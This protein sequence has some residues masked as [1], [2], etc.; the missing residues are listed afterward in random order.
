M[1]TTDLLSGAAFIEAQALFPADTDNEATPF[2]ILLSSDLE[3]GVSDFPF[4]LN[5]T[6]DRRDPV[7]AEMRFPAEGYIDYSGS[8]RGINWVMALEKIASGWSIERGLVAFGDEAGELQIS[9]TKTAPPAGA[10]Y[11]VDAL[12]GATLTSVGV[13]NLVRFWMGENGFGPFLKNL[14]AG[15][16]S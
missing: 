7:V 3:G 10:E 11:H 15:E 12:A 8:M 16:I 9:V 14:Q 1:P 2:R 4:P 5:K 13:N 6:A